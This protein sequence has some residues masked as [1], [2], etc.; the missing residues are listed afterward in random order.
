MKKYSRLFLY[1]ITASILSTSLSG[2]G[3]S[4]KNP[5]SAV[6]KPSPASQN[7]DFTSWNKLVEARTAL[8]NKNY[9]AVESLAK[10]RISEKPDDA[11]AHFMLGQA[12]TGQRRYKEARKS[13]ETASSLAPDNLNYYREFC[14]SLEA[15]AQ[16]AESN[17]EYT[18]AIALYRK[19]LEK[20]YEPDKTESALADLYIGSAFKSIKEGNNADAE[21][22]LNEGSNLLKKN[23][24]IKLALAK[25]FI[26]DNRL[27]EAERLLKKLISTNSNN[28]ECLATYATLL[29]KMGD[30]SKATEIAD[31]ALAIDS[32]NNEAMLVKNSLESDM[33]V[34]IINPADNMNLSLE[35]INERIKFF[36]KSG[37]LTEEKALLETCLKQYPDQTGAYYKLAEVCEKLGFI[38]EA[39]Q[40]IQQFNAINT[41]SPEGMF[42]YAKCL[43][44]KGLC[45]DSLNILA[46]LENSY[47]DKLALLNERGQALARKGDFNSAIEVWNS[48]LQKNPSNPDANF[49]L[50][51]LSNEMGK[52]DEANAFY[53]KAI[54]QQPFN[55]KFKY[56][57]GINFIQ[58]GNKNKAAELWTASK[59]TLNASEPYAARILRALGEDP[60]LQIAVANSMKSEMPPSSL[61]YADAR[62]IA[63][64]SES[65]VEN[66]STSETESASYE[67]ALDCA[68]KGDF[69]TAERL[70][71]QVTK[72]EPDNFNA[73][74]NLGKI[75]TATSKHNIASA[76]FLKAL[77]I[78]SRNI[79]ALRALANS[80][81]EVG[82]HSLANQISE[83]VKTNYPDQFQDF[84]IYGNKTIK[85]DPRAVESMVTALLNEGL[86]NE[87]LAVVQG[88]I[89]EQAEN[90]NLYLLQ[91]DV[92]KQMKM[93]DLS[94]DSYRYVQN[95]DQQS[96]T[97]YIRIADLYLASGQ[98]TQA[99]QEYRKA[100][101]TPFIDPDSMF[102][103][104]DRYAQMGRQSE[105]RTLLGKL[106]TM[107]LNIEQV[108]MLDQRLGTNV[109][110][111]TTASSALSEE[112]EKK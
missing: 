62:V 59:A 10:K 21:S 106:R 40:A 38:D 53:D 4:K 56:F 109:A 58:S 55:N 63:I 82:M 29:H 110:E 100:L 32:S 66:Y 78:D 57:A 96:P 11:S 50:G 46:S 49:Y 70:F 83:Q 27:M 98:P 12:L 65:P 77:K 85:N 44:Q 9:E 36:E 67:E 48:V 112:K 26:D 61:E 3:G 75:Y 47:A 23:V 80:Y 22:V 74:M 103:I 24:D 69:S 1:L 89:S 34:I 64:D 42:L 41:A 107:N 97:S 79:H 17:N 90:N 35:A 111:E 68:R 14:K 92:Y 71:R 72:N 104:S 7:S 93:F 18:E 108:K 105:A 16:E 2:C 6:S 43:C 20:N 102:Y 94:M 13:L 87:A 45:D 5:V 37:N 81:S 31:K 8:D 95:A 15:N 52:F 33:P 19:L 30:N 86:I 84:P 91:G 60:E 73:M 76:I 51:Q 101:A 99:L 39:I 28:A 88:A 25:L 54:R